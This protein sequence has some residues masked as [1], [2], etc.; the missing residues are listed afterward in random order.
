MLA[1][2]I[3]HETPPYFHAY[4]DLVSMPDIV[5]GLQFSMDE[6]MMLVDKIPSSKRNYAYAPGKWTIA[7]V[8][9]HIIDCERIFACRA[10]RLSRMDSTPLPGFDQ[11]LYTDNLKNK[12]VDFTTLVEE[13]KLVRL[14]SV[15]L[16]KQMDEEML[17]FEG[18]V[19]GS[20]VTA[21]AYGYIINGHNLHHNNI[22]LNRYL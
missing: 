15:L 1:E 20:P 17:Q 16:Y 4:I 6:T 19:N 10:L 14:S 8:L 12:T 5:T 11:D 18:T 22:I 13:Y 9:R 7:E 2:Q 3:Y 21:R